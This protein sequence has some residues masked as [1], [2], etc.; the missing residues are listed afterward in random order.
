MCVTAILRLDTAPP[1]KVAY[2]MSSA[3]ETKPRAG[4]MQAARNGAERKQRFLR[5]AGYARVSRVGTRDDDRLRSPDF[6][7]ELV[8]ELATR[9]GFELVE[10]P[11]ELDVSGSRPS[12]AILDRIIASIEAGELDGLAVAKLDRLSRLRPKDRI[13][14]VERIEAAGGVIRSASESLDASTPEGVLQR[15]IF[16]GIARYQLEKYS[17][18]WQLAKEAAMRDGIAIKTSAPFGLRFDARHRLELDPEAAA[19]VLELFEARAGEPPASYAELADI[20]ERRTGWRPT[21][22][23]IG[24]I[25]KNRVYLGELRYGRD[26]STALVNLEPGFEAIVPLELFERVQRVNERRS[27]GRGVA[28]G[29]AKSLLAGI[30]KCANCGRSLTSSPSR[31][32]RRYKC[33]ADNPRECSARANINAAALDAYVIERVLEWAG[34]VADE[35]VDV[36]LELTGDSARLVAA[37]RLEQAEAALIAHEVNVELE[38][39]VGRE[40][41]EAGRRERVELRNRRRDE[42]EQ[43]GEASELAHARA[44]VRDVLA[45]DESTVDERRALLAVVLDRVVVRRTPYPRAPVDERVELVFRALAT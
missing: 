20:V 7:L 13:E 5:L 43:L 31:G 12:R 19:V 32:V 33:S 23:A 45:G 17:Q 27:V 41:Y 37:R 38:L 3:T 10:Y 22:R 18:G 24:Y 39:E 15:E 14:L 8:R 9:E 25:L 6:Q 2:A 40:A 11:A 16:F 30:A 21:R 44:S 29:R 36:E 42:L 1:G 4:R 34:P 35:V 28:V 26:E